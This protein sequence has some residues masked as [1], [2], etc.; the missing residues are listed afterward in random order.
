MAGHRARDDHG[1]TLVELL[2]AFTLLGLIAVLFAG[3]FQF[4]ARI[5]E[6]GSERAE[7]GEEVRVA[8]GLLR[9]QLARSVAK[10]RSRQD[11]DAPALFQ[12][13]RGALSFLAPFPAQDSDDG[14]YRQSLTLE[15]T[16]DGGQLIYAWSPLAEGDAEPAAV[17]A[18][19]GRVVLL[20]RVAALESAYFDPGD[21]ETP[22]GWRDGWAAE[23]LP[24]LVR[25]RVE[26]E[27]RKRQPWPALIV[28]LQLAN[29]G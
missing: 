25:L 11:G 3:A 2:V 20:E 1:F 8:Q 14:L 21:D 28:A 26:F 10:L 15:R 12:G 29:G 17:E 19:S 22:A 23:T 9:R 5:W 13:T 7:A 18:A 27:D 24:R 16:K 4:G 6:S